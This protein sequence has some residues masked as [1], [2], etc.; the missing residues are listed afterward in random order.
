[1]TTRGEFKYASGWY[2]IYI[3]RDGIIERVGPFETE[4]EARLEREKME[5]ENATQQAT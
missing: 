5:E 1:M 2:G 3:T 4:E